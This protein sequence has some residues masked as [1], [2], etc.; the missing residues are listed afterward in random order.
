MPD[1]KNYLYFIVF[2]LIFIYQSGICQENYNPTKE[3]LEA[4]EWF[5]DAK[6]GMFIHWGV[7]STL[8]RGEWVMEVEKIPY[9][10][11]ERL[12]TFFDPEAF[13]PAAWVKTAKDAGMKYIT[14]TS[15]HHDGFSMFDSKVTDYDIMD[16]TRYKKDVLKMLAEECRKQDMKLFFYYSHLDWHHPDYYPLGKTGKS[17]GRKEGGDWNKYLAFMNA[18]LTELLSNY[19]LIAG[20]W[21]DGWWDKNDADWQL[22]KQYKLI[23]KLQPQ[24][25]IGNNHHRAPIPG[26]DFQMFERDLPGQ[27]TSGYSPESKI[28]AL[29]LEICETINNTWGYNL[30]DDQYKSVKSLIHYLVKAA[31]HNANFLL[32]IGPMPN[33]EIQ[34]EFADTL[35]VV[36]KWLDTYG[37]TIYGTRGGPV[38][39]QSWGVSTIKGDKVYLHILDYQ[40]MSILLPKMDKKIKSAKIFDNKENVEL[41][42][43]KEGTIVKLPAKDFKQHDLIIELEI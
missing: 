42:Q 19:G 37:E 40:N 41:L 13:D 21:F 43:T 35:K 23:H 11:Y 30:K 33:G 4:R 8:A 29:P 16:Q 28:G 20:I 18:Q 12:P 32:N 39:A 7:Y 15:R 34:K 6:F 3:N 10:T 9:K 1:F 5:Q 31:G 26:E 25:L 14:I 22:E 27:N 2:S 38:P 36:G 17:S 24:T